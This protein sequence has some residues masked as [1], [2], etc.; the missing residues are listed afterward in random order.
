MLGTVA[1]FCRNNS[2]KTKSN[3]SNNKSKEVNMKRVEV[4]LFSFLLLPI[5]IYGQNSHQLI[6]PPFTQNSQY[7]NNVIQGD[8]ATT[9]AR[10]DSSRIYVLVRGGLYLV[11]YQI[12]NSK[13][14]LSVKAQDSSGAKP[15]IF[16]VKNT[17]TGK[18]TGYFVQNSGNV[19]LKNLAIVGYLDDGS[20]GVHD[21]NYVGGMPGGL[22]DI[23]T[24]G[25]GYNIVVDSCVLSECSGQPIRTDGA[26]K[27][28]YVTNT[29]FANLGYLGTSNLGAGKGFD[30]RAGSCDT[31]LIQNCTFVNVQDRIIR[32]LNSTAGIAHVIFDHNT[33]V[34]DMS[35]HGMISVGW[36]TTDCRIT[37]NLFID[38]FAL[39][40]DTDGTRETEFLNGEVNQFGRPRMTWVIED[41]NTRKL[42]VKWNISNNYY[43]ISDSGKAFYNRHLA[44]GLGSQYPYTPEGSPLTWFINGQLEAQGGD[45]TTAFRKVTLIPKT[46]PTLMTAEMEWYR[47]PSGGN[48]TKNTPTSLWN[49]SDDMDRK[50]ID[51]ILDTLNCSYTFVADTDLSVAGT[52]GKIIGST[53]WTGSGVITPRVPALASPNDTTGVPR[54]ATLNWNAAYGAA[55]YRI[56]VASDIGFS[57]V[58]ADTTLAKTTVKLSAALTA[59]TK[60][61]WHVAAVNDTLT[62]AYSAPD[63]FTTGTGV[64]AVAEHSGIPSVFYLN[65]NY[66]NPFN[67]STTIKYGLPTE[68]QVQIAIYNVL[69]QRVGLLVDQRMSA[70]NYEAVFNADKYA[71]GV[72]FYVMHAGDKQFIQ[73]MLLL[74]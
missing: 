45:S 58:V 32:H 65:Q 52:D 2:D 11:N 19:W 39:G 64:D 8:T 21:T 1:E 40:S 5:T 9:G 25:A 73:K 62:S 42:D 56:Q 50:T 54:K 69:G 23:P 7:L 71:S 14:T 74:K 10:N 4:L 24:S 34:N 55:K 43:G 18:N 13:W 53:M 33:V 31:L 17:T 16:L 49:A 12:L 68:T 61:Y 27:E 15:V 29:V 26:A 35:Y 6:V 37:N 20:G 67:P 63:S 48:K 41:S 22:I 3:S 47:S 36:V 72:Y 28:I 66:P 60:Y 70:G 30:L 59:S 44:Q 46:I 57:S 51:W 38:P